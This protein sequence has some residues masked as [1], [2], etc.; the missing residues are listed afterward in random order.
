MKSY[1]NFIGI[2]IGKFSFVVSQYGVKKTQEYANTELGI[3]EFI[4][5]YSNI[6]PG[7]LS[8]YQCYLKVH[9]SNCDIFI[10]VKLYS[11]VL[12]R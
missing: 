9:V 3:T 11:S 6:L 12:T 8:I 2:D 4:E 1:N 5:Y 10:S 7:S